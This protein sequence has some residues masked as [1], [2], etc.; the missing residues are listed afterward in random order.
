MEARD[1]ARAFINKHFPECDVAFLAGSAARGQ[2]T[3]TS[4]LDIVVFTSEHVHY[5]KSTHD[6]GWPIEV[7]VEDSAFYRDYIRMPI[8]G[9]PTMAFMCAEGVPIK[10]TDGM[11]QRIKDEACQFIEAGPIPLTKQQI[12]NLRYG[13]TKL[14]EDFTDTENNGENIFN[15]NRLTVLSCHLLLSHKHQ[16][17]GE[18][19]WLLRSLKAADMNLAQRLVEAL[20]AFYRNNRKEKL[21]DFVNETLEPVGGK[22]SDGYT[23]DFM[24]H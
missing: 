1:A 20:E 4:D 5:S 7:F 21:I 15:A 23:I 24:G 10:D 22:L 13:I 17:I 9:C 12:M 8:N 18:G 16:W 3:A 6:F 2:E 11:A 19:K 14:L